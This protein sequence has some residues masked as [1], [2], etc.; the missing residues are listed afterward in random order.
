MEGREKGSKEDR[1]GMAHRERKREGRE[2][3]REVEES[4]EGIG[5]KS[6]RMGLPDGYLAQKS[7]SENK[8][9]P[10]KKTKKNL[11]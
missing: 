10:E 6:G 3:Q 2:N 1:E 11:N 5:S 8:K 4:W 7:V 9:Y